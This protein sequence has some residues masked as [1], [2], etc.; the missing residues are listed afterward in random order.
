MTTLLA[1][2]GAVGSVAAALFSLLAWIDSRERQPFALRRVGNRV[3]LTRIK[4]P[5]VQLRRVY[6][7]GHSQLVSAD[8]AATTEWRILRHDGQLALALDG[9]YP[10]GS[11]GSVQFEVAPTETVTVVYRRVWLWDWAA[12]RTRLPRRLSGSDNR[13]PGQGK[14]RTR[15]KQEYLDRNDKATVWREWHSSL[16]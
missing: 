16:L 7:F 9:S 10:D 14:A 8:Q 11:G 15:R 6:V 12:S 4:R 13:G 2:V 1:V 3:L 5:T